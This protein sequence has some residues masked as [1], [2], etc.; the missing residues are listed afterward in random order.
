MA[1]LLCVV[2]SGRASVRLRDARASLEAEANRW[3]GSDESQDH[4]A[5]TWTQGRSHRPSQRSLLERRLCDA[6]QL[7]EWGHPQDLG[8]PAEAVAQRDRRSALG[9]SRRAP[10]CASSSRRNVLTMTCCGADA[11]SNV[12]SNPS[13]VSQNGGPLVARGTSES[14]SPITG[15]ASDAMSQRCSPFSHASRSRPI[16]WRGSRSPGTC[17]CRRQALRH[18][19]GTADPGS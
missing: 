12:S 9:R 13:S 6:H 19:P 7:V 2:P 4:Q 14:R 15:A 16:L 1:R 5:P 17:R 10:A 18:M 8:F 11:R 3:V